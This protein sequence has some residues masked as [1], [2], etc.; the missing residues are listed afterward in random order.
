MEWKNHLTISLSL[1]LLAVIPE[2]YP[3]AELP[4]R[5]LP[6]LAIVAQSP[7]HLLICHLLAIALLDAP[8]IGQSLLV[9]GGELEAALVSVHP[10]DTV[11]HVSIPQQVE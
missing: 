7:R 3:I 10:P 6:C 9:F 5:N 2:R 8:A 11:L 1:S 4:T